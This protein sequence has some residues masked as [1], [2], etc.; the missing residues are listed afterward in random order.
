MALNLPK[1]I[2]EYL[3]AVEEKNSDKLARCF[4]EDAV[5]HDEGGAYRGRDAIKSWSEETQR[6]YAYS[7]EA[8]DALL[9]GNTM[10]VR[11]KV[12]G[13]FPGS[14]VE[15]D[16]LFTVANEKIISLKIE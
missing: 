15:L 1:P 9:T 12:T 5:V 3:A 8:L 6:K 14:P 7:M 16:Y 2:A 11:A 10:R 13:S 4:A